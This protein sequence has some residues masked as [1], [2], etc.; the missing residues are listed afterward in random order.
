MPHAP[1]AHIGSVLCYAISAVCMLT[2]GNASQF[3]QTG[4]VCP[5]PQ[6][7]AVLAYKGFNSP[8]LSVTL[9]RLRLC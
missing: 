8:L 7:Q 4:W 2:A 9:D 1:R 3:V 6:E 5:H